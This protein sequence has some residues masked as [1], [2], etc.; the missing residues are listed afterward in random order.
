MEAEIVTHTHTHTQT[1]VN[2][3]QTHTS[4]ELIILLL[5]T[6]SHMGWLRLVGYKIIGLFCK[7]AVLK[8]LYSVNETYNLIDPTNFIHPIGNLRLAT[9]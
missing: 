6:D 1:Q 2:T 5:V 9:V 8:R 3:V 4:A 7:R